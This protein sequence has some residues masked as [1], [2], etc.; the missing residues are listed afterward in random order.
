MAESLSKTENRYSGIPT[1]R[2]EMKEWG[3]KEPVFKENRNEFIVILYNEEEISEDLSISDRVL[4]FC[5]QPRTRKEI[6][7]LLDINTLAY[8]YSR[9][10]EPLIKTGKLVLLNPNETRSRNHRYI[11]K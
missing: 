6:A 5:E 11:R 3:L 8:A 7:N 2:R 1:I 10:I 4:K 9:Y